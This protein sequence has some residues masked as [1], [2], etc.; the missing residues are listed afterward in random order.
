VIEAAFLTDGQSAEW[1]HFCKGGLNGTFLHSRRFLS[2]HGTRF[3]DRSL[4]VRE[5]GQ[6]VAVLPLAQS[7]GDAT[8][9]V[10]HPGATYGGLVHQ[11][12]VRGMRTIEALEA[13]ASALHAAGYMRMQYKPVPHIY[14]QVP[15]QDDLYALF[16]LGARRFRCD[17]SSSIDLTN[18]GAPS[19]RRR[20]GLKKALRSVELQDGAEQLPALWAVLQDNL[21]RKHDAQP[22]HSLQEMLE[23][24]QRFP[25]EIAVRVACIAGRVEAGVVLFRCGPVWHAQYIA[26]SQAAY[27]VSAL[28]AV[29]DGAI[30]EAKGAG[31]RYFDFGTSN[32][33]GGQ[34]L[35]DG[36]YR[37]K[38]EFGGGG[39]AYEQYEIELVR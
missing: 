15:A 26:A 32:E 13:C 23:L 38:T 20:R 29:F 9:V 27:D 30:T 8:V 1:D 18:R 10:S 24:C 19:E 6:L 11:G 14:H 37:F 3:V 34:V 16:R 31:A 36:L 12:K 39:V 28:D 2:Y 21:A 5:D 17:L 7:S 35:N 4:M 22:V 25:Q 33:E